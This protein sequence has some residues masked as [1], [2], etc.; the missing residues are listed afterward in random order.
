MQAIRVSSSRWR[1]DCLERMGDI[2]LPARLK[3]RSTGA[4]LAG[5][6]DK[7][8][9]RICMVYFPLIIVYTSVYRYIRYTIYDLFVYRIH[10]SSRHLAN[11]SNFKFSKRLASLTKKWLNLLLKI[12][13]SPE[14]LRPIS[15]YHSPEFNWELHQLLKISPEIL[16]NLK[17]IFPIL[18]TNM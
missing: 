1:G 10:Y 2:I 9:Y 14:F 11:T 5:T 17:Q 16:N 8:K 3:T 18:C 13:F 6:Y 12:E 4:E 15:G 7:R